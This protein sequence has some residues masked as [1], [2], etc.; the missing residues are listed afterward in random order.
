M[1][2]WHW[3]VT[4]KAKTTNTFMLM[5]VSDDAAQL[6]ETAS[7]ILGTLLSDEDNDILRLIVNPGT[8]RHYR[9]GLPI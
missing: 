2:S 6:N 3:P 9:V 5:A 7:T 8:F 1:F 4:A